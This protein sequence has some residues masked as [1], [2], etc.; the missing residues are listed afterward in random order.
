MKQWMTREQYTGFC[1]GNS[2]KYLGRFNLSASGKGGMNDLLK[3]KQY[4]DWLIA[5]ESEE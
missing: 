5:V 3:A 4:L 2:L 1:L